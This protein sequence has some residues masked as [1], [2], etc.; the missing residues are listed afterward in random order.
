MARATT[1]PTTLAFRL[2]EHPFAKSVF[3]ENAAV[4]KAAYASGKATD[5]DSKPVRD[6]TEAEWYVRSCGFALAHLL[7]LLQQLAQ[8]PGYI[9]QYRRTDALAARSVT[10]ASDV[11]Y[12]LENFLVRT[13]SLQDR[14]L[15]LCSAVMHTGLDLR[16][17]SYVRM[18]RNARVQSTGLD[19]SLKAINELCQ[20][21]S[22]TR[23]QVIHQH[24]LLDGELRRVE[25][26]L[27]GSRVVNHEKRGA[28]ASSYRYLVQDLASRKTAEFD[29]FTRSA[30][31]S[32]D[33]LFGALAPQYSRM[34]ARLTVL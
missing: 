26:I 8:I 6:L 4:L 7:G 2:G 9:T 20:K 14:A 15:Q 23:N 12:H 11:T 10:R 17:V 16:D 31:S 5:I 24:G 22:Q 34:K 25:L 32:V 33:Q 3:S 13:Q 21:Y 29:E 28:M 30:I 27:M 19:V 1:K 18:I